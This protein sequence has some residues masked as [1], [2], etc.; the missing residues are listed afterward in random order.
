[1]DGSSLE[2][3]YYTVVQWQ[4]D[5][6]LPLYHLEVRELE[7]KEIPRL[8]STSLGLCT[9]EERDSRTF[10]TPSTP[11]MTLSIE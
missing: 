4:T 6:V 9:R 7:R 2:G 5:L 3:N 11:D 10:P 8:I 1:M